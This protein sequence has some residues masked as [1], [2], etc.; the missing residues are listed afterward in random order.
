LRL[1]ELQPVLLLSN[2]SF[3]APLS[4]MAKGWRRHRERAV[5]GVCEGRLKAEGLALPGRDRNIGSYC[6]RI[7]YHRENPSSSPRGG[8]RHSTYSS[9]APPDVAQTCLQSPDATLCHILRHCVRHVYS[10][11]LLGLKSRTQQ[12][13][14]PVPVPP[15]PHNAASVSACQGL[16]NHE[17][18]P[19]GP[20]KETAIPFHHAVPP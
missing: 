16:P 7:Q 12:V 19:P 4:V 8:R 13:P 20:E 14:V 9:H 2:A 11:P 3:P 5:Y 18:P 1:V 15:W 10:T 6:I 17:C